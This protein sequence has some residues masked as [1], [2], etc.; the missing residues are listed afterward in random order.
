MTTQPVDYR[1]GNAKRIGVANQ[2]DTE[3]EEGVAARTLIQGK[4]DLP[5]QVARPCLSAVKREEEARSHR[6]VEAI[7][8]APLEEKVSLPV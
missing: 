7:G 4:E 2:V 3:H 8:N 1:L 5:G 6:V